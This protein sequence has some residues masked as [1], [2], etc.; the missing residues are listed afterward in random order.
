MKHKWLIVSF[1]ILSGLLAM[2]VLARYMP[3]NTLDNSE[4][5]GEATGESILYGEAW[6]IASS[7]P[8]IDQGNLVGM[9][10]CN[11]STGTVWIDMDIDEPGCYPACVVNITSRESEINW[12]C[13]GLGV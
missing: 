3:G 13:T 7:G 1:L 10:R 9:A 12:R 5:A 11:P 4:C 8:C 6:V 2:H